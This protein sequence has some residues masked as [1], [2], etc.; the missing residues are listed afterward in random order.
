MAGLWCSSRARSFVWCV[1][2]R[3]AWAFEA[4]AAAAVGR[5][6]GE[7]RSSRPLSGVSMSGRYIQQKLGNG[8]PLK[9][10]RVRDSHFRLFRVFC[11]HCFCLFSV[12]SRQRRQIKPPRMSQNHRK[13]PRRSPTQKADRRSYRAHVRSRHHRDSRVAVVSS[14]PFRRH[15]PEPKGRM[16]TQKQQ[17][18]PKSR[19]RSDAEK[20]LLITDCPPVER[21][22]NHGIEPGA[23]EG[24][25]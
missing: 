25:I 17:T 8:V 22:K 11:A 3:G 16:R 15:M 20:H 18:R 24:G 9:G 21:E 2:P 4:Q 19:E 7:M 13:H 6:L 5:L 14:L 12:I 10:P 23:F 1:T